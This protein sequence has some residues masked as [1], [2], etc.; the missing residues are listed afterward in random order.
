MVSVT[1]YT[2]DILHY[3]T[4]VIILYT[5]KDI[6][7]KHNLATWLRVVKFTELKSIEFRFF[8]FQSYKLLLRNFYKSN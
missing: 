8:Q 7:S 2:S 4:S 3:I 1:G 5:L 6:H